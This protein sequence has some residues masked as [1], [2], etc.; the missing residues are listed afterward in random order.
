MRDCFVCLE[1][2]KSRA[3][4][5]FFDARV[6]EVFEETNAFFD[7]GSRVHDQ[8]PLKLCIVLR[9]SAANILDLGLILTRWSAQ[10]PSRRLSKARRFEN[11]KHPHR[12]HSFPLYVRT[13]L[14][15][16]C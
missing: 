13:M 7:E 5:Q 16:Q 12:L 1:G 2:P 15:S 9:G 3:I 8:S 4:Y 11:G 6:V 10:S 14:R